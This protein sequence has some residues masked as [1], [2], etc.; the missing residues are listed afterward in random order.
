MSRTT[1]EQYYTYETAPDAPELRGLGITS[2]Q[3]HRWGEQR[4]LTI[5]KFGNRVLIPSSSLR[6]LVERSTFKARQKESH[7]QSAV[8]YEP[9]A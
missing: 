4:K 2:R 1:A 6:E 5:I 9:E 7:G 3:L 8:G